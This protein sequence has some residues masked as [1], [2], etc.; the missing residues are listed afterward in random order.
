MRLNGCFHYTMKNT[1]NQINVATE[2]NFQNEYK[3][4]TVTNVI[5]NNNVVS[6][7]KTKC[8]PHFSKKYFHPQTI[9]F[10]K[11]LEYNNHTYQPTRTDK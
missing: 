8:N 2:G 1:K 9:D 6:A 3:N 10:V 11:K 4:T 7:R 5:Y